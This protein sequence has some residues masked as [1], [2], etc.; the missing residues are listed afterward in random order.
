MLNRLLLC[1]NSGKQVCHEPHRAVKNTAQ[2]VIKI[3][4]QQSTRSARNE[5]D[6]KTTSKCCKNTTKQNRICCKNATVNC[7]NLVTKKFNIETLLL[8]LVCHNVYS[9]NYLRSYTNG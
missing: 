4:K 2:V 5:C 1:R 8:Q 7:N 9:F 3:S 6:K